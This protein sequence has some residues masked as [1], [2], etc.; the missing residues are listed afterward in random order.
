MKKIHS[1]AIFEVKATTSGNPNLTMKNIS[2]FLKHRTCPKM[3]RTSILLSFL[4]IFLVPTAYSQTNYLPEG[5]QNVISEKWISAFKIAL[6]RGRFTSKPVKIKDHPEIKAA[7]QLNTIIPPTDMWEQQIFTPT[8]TKVEEGDNLVFSFYARTISTINESTPGFLACVFEKASPDWNKSLHHFHELS[9]EWKQY[10]FPFKSIADYKPGEAQVCIQI[11]GKQQV[12]EIA[13]IK[14]VN[15]KRKF[16]PNELPSSLRVDVNKKQDIEHLTEVADKLIGPFPMNAMKNHI[17]SGFAEV[18]KAKVEGQ[19]FT[20]SYLISVKMQ[21]KNSE[22]VQLL[23]GN[24]L[25]VEKGDVIFVTFKARTLPVNGGRPKT[26][27]YCNFEP[28]KPPLDRSLNELI[29]LD[30]L[31]KEFSYPFTSKDTYESGFA[32]FTFYC[33]AYLQTI[34]IADL[35]VLNYRKTLPIDKLPK[36]KSYTEADYSVAS[37][38]FPIGEDPINKFHM[39]TLK[40]EGTGQIIPVSGQAFTEAYQ[41]IGTTKS[42]NAK[43]IQCFAFTEAKV[44]KDDVMLLRFYARAPKSTTNAPGY[45]TCNFSKATPNYDKALS[46]KITLTKDWKMYQMPFKPPVDFEVGAAKLSFYIGGPLLQNVEIAKVELINY[47]KTK[48]ITDFPVK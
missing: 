36:T 48:K 20:E 26:K 25:K 17:A 9:K 16:A 12:I 14:V 42:E 46:R 34:E 39:M 2:Q 40:A 30:T 35:Q 23:A 6:N 10:Y 45:L 8:K 31:W 19:S 44:S 24:T 27:V 38:K 4:L 28:N 13:N 32:I 7:I 47:Q 11:G 43:D 33:G 5:G 1:F 18:R 29:I 37:T 22:D 3:A 41:L 15:Y 21:P